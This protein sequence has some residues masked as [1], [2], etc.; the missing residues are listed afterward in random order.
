MRGPESGYHLL[1]AREYTCPGCGQA[2]QPGE[3]YVLA[4]GYEEPGFSLH[5]SE[6]APTGVERR[7]HVEHFRRQLGDRVFV[8]VHEESTTR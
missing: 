2:L 5:T 4:R 6:G 8:L 7:F 1:V 3:D